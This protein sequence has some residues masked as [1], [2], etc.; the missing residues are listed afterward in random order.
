[1]TI[2]AT[3]AL[4]LWQKFEG[5]WNGV[6][7]EVEN[8]RTSN[9]ASYHQEG[10]D[11]FFSFKSRGECH[12]NLDV[13]LT[14]HMDNKVS[15]LGLRKTWGFFWGSGCE[16]GLGVLANECKH[17]LT[18]GILGFTHFDSKFMTLKN[19]ALYYNMVYV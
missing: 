16:K 17:I 14:P 12:Y 15:F 18:E 13:W 2:V 4:K 6:E 5:T 9:E 3:F 19:V 8:H 1:L 10:I 7:N 11:P